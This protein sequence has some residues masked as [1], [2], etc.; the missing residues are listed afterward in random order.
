VSA[1]PCTTSVEDT[2]F[3]IHVEDEDD[4]REVVQD[5][6]EAVFGDEIDQ[7]YCLISAATVLQAEEGLT[8]ALH[9]SSIPPVLIVDLDLH[10]EEESADWDGLLWLVRHLERIERHEVELIIWSSYINRDMQLLSSLRHL[11]LPPEHI[12]AKEVDV[13]DVIKVITKAMDQVRKKR[14]LPPRPIRATERNELAPPPVCDIAA[15]FEGF[16]DSSEPLRVSTSRPIYHLTVQ[17][18]GLPELEKHPEILQEEIT[19]VCACIGIELS[20]PKLTLTI[21]EYGH[22]PNSATFRLRFLPVPR[23][24]NRKVRVFIYHR[25]YLLDMLVFDIEVEN[26][27]E[28]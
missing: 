16:E 3:V 14:A 25:N 23:H 15:F 18:T 17:V 2:V 27:W 20:D 9:F 1:P 12:V 28:S 8:T 24:R 7:P 11:N 19:I 13:E 4:I 22:R 21:P 10:S 6:L 26:D 5:E